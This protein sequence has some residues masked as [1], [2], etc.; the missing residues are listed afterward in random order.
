MQRKAS[1]VERKEKVMKVIII[2]GDAAGMSA[3][4][5]LK[6]MAKDTEVAVYEKGAY[7]S[8]AACGLPYFISGVIE[9]QGSLISRTK[10]D[11][12]KAG[13]VCRLNHEVIEVVPGEKKVAVRDIEKGSIFYDYYDKLLVASGAYPV[14]PPFPGLELGNI[15]TLKTMDDGINL[16]KLMMSDSIRNVAIIGGG[17]IGVEMA[18][19][20]AHLGKNTTMIELMP[21]LLT[22]FDEEFSEIAREE[23]EKNGVSV[24]LNEK[25]VGFEGDGRV[26]KV[27]TDKGEYEVDMV[28]LSVGIKPSLDFLKDV[29]IHRGRNGALVVDREMRT[30]I[31]DIYAAGDCAQIYH[32]GKMENAYIPLG[33]TAN[34]GGRIAGENLAGNHKKY[35]GAL[36]SAAIKIFDKNMARTGLSEKEASDL[37]IDYETVMVVAKSNA[38]YC[39]SSK[40][41]RIKIISERCTGK[42][43]GAQAAG[44][45][46]VVLRVDVLAVAIH[47]GMT[48]DEIGFVDLCYAPP[49]ASAWDVINIAGNAAA[50]RKK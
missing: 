22:P 14:R 34:K 10:D 35:V 13:I 33:T 36:G 39:P 11:F 41:V 28:L 6:R 1:Y 38:G 44:E 21:R 20:S 27:I 45:D 7:V 26:R 4:S 49:F 31:E 16:R 15:H 46:G 8:Y 29:D 9:E 47:A 30:S 2:G 50:S 24:R 48:T 12:E 17:Y 5:K 25:V 3:A 32:L 42:I 18:E 40:P 43:L 19:A 37:G 23:I